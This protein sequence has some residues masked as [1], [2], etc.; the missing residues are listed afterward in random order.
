MVALRVCLRKQGGLSLRLRAVLLVAVLKHCEG[1]VVDSEWPGCTKAQAIGRCCDALDAYVDIANRGGCGAGSQVPPVQCSAAST[2]CLKCR[3]DL[4]DYNSGI[5]VALGNSTQAEAMLQLQVTCRLPETET[6]SGTISGLNLKIVLVV[7][8]VLLLA[9]IFALVV[10]DRNVLPA[11][12]MRF[13]AAFE[14]PHS[15][16]DVD[17]GGLPSPLSI[18]SLQM[19][20]ISRCAAP[21]VADSLRMAASCTLSPHF[22]SDAAGVLGNASP[23]P[24]PL[25]K[26]PELS[27]KILR[28]KWPERLAT[29]WAS[30]SVFL[31]VA[32][33]STCLRAVQVISCGIIIELGPDASVWL[34]PEPVICLLMLARLAWSSRP[35]TDSDNGVP[36]R[37]AYGPPC[38][39]IP[40]FTFFGALVLLLQFLTLIASFFLTTS[41]PCSMAPW[42]LQLLYLF[43]VPCTAAQAYAALLAVR[44]QDEIVGACRRVMP[45]VVV[46]SPVGSSGPLE[47]QQLEGEGN[48]GAVV[49]GK[50][51]DLEEFQLEEMRPADKLG[52]ERFP[53]Q[54]SEPSVMSSASVSSRSCFGLCCGRGTVR[55]PFVGAQESFNAETEAPPICSCLPDWCCKAMRKRL[56]QQR[57]VLWVSL[58]ILGLAA[59]G[60]AVGASLYTTRKAPVSPTLPSSCLTARNATTTCKNFQLAGAALY[61]ATTGGPLMESIRSV[62]DCCSK[63]DGLSECQ[64]WLFEY[65]GK[66]CK[67]IRF[68]ESPCDVNPADLRCRCLTGPAMGFGFKSPAPLVSFQR[69]G[70]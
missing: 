33:C 18:A 55:R 32:L 53:S 44:M 4:D 64:A 40:R 28:G 48:I 43:G 13:K 41:A 60:S 2:L 10:F 9:S 19:Q 42:K 30:R 39:R 69:P 20:G 12:K 37:S 15:D 5:A 23:H 14:L 25:P 17:L 67:W 70:Q 31:L 22:E 6:C 11:L 34:V 59:V 52:E 35:P 8:F 16:V 51:L 1:Q 58:A 29:V 66:T 46:G 38:Q 24:P 27:G 49:C 45:V 50:P 7:G 62:E 61:D 65:Y 54:G 47:S 56:A 36:L 57:L 26:D 3:G 63:C 21:S 68:S